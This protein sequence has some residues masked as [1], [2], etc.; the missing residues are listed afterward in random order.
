MIADVFDTFFYLTYDIIYGRYD[1]AMKNL[2]Y[3]KSLLN[4]Y[5]VPDPKHINKIFFVAS[6]DFVYVVP[7]S[8]LLPYIY[9]F[10]NHPGCD[11]ES[12]Y[13]N[14]IRI[15]RIFISKNIF[16]SRKFDRMDFNNLKEMIKLFEMSLY[17][18]VNLEPIK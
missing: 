9:Y 15:F 7:Y 6:E 8:K 11:L 13:G 18:K 3:I 14:F 10:Y 12:L 2:K 5:Y 17:A 1:C 16:V 4:L